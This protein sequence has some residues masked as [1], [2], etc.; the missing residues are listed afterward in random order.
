MKIPLPPGWLPMK[1]TSR[2]QTSCTLFIAVSCAITSHCPSMWQN[3]M[4][5]QNM[6]LNRTTATFF[7]CHCETAPLFWQNFLGKI[8]IC[9]SPTGQNTSQVFVHLHQ[10]HCMQLLRGTITLLTTCYS[11]STG[12]SCLHWIKDSCEV[13]DSWSG[14]ALAFHLP[15][16]LC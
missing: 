6:T 5:F 15:Q 16:M 8:C 4:N 10:S 2:Q 1:E 3:W 12:H 11:W 7:Y 9:A 13:P 14:S